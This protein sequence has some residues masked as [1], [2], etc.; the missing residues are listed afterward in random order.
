MRLRPIFLDFETFWAASH[1]L[2]SMNPILYVKH[3]DTEIL[4]CAVQGA[5]ILPTCVTGEKEVGDFL[6]RID[7]SDKLVVGHNMSGFDSLIL[8]WRY[9]IKPAM[10]GCTLAMARPLHGLSVG[11][12]LKALAALY[13]LGEKNSSAIM[14]TKGKHLKD[15][16]PFELA[17][18]QSYNLEDTRLCEELFYRLMPYTSKDELRL[19]DMTTRMLVEPQFEVD[20]SLLRITLKQEQERTRKDLLRLAKAIGIEDKYGALQHL[21]SENEVQLLDV[22][23][24]LAGGV[25]EIAEL[26]RSEMASAQK[27]AG[28]L[29]SWGVIPPT[30]PSPT[31]PSKLT[32]AFAR[33]DDD[34]LA[35]LNHPNPLVSAAVQMRLDVKSTILESR[36]K[37]FLD[38]SDATGGKMPIAKNYYAA[39]T[40]RWGGCLVADTEV[41]VYDTLCDVAQ[42]KRIVDV[43]L[44]D[45]VWDGEA[46]VAHA[47]VSFSGYSEVIEWDGVKGTADHVV[48]V[49]GKEISLRDALQGRVPI[50][51]GRDPTEDDMD[52]AR[53]HAHHNK[54]AAAM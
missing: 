41:L 54:N 1:T 5:G 30:K 44:S 2:T 34:F 52:A 42:Q 35:L 12:A 37:A 14:N 53:I 29:I 43:L 21:D 31:N 22:I 25:D 18:L 3:K 33:S 36:M 51:I 11:G 48:F 10:W 50:K 6:H 9:G 16:T 32:Y 4:S 19:I 39:H 24:G 17:E 13:N 8:A 49:D 26:V 38:V 23:N 20:R 46:F 40:G 47:G 7:W 15:F 45:L 27:F 28:R